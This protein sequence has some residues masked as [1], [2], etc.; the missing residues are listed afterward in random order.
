MNE[1]INE[2]IIEEMDG[3]PIIRVDSVREIL[4][5]LNPRLDGFKEIKAFKKISRDIGY[6]TNLREQCRQYHWLITEGFNEDNYF[7][8][9]EEWNSDYEE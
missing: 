1:D 9:A 6:L 7:Y 5:Y 4:K 2:D 8:L 3:V